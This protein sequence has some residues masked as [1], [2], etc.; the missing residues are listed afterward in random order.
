MPV[1]DDNEAPIAS[2]VVPEP[3]FRTP[4]VAATCVEVALVSEDG[5]VV[6][7]VLIRDSKNLG[8]PPIVMSY[9]LFLKLEASPGAGE[10]VEG[11]SVLAV[12]EAP[13]GWYSVGLLGTGHEL[14]FSPEE[15]SVFVDGCRDSFFDVDRYGIAA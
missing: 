6:D 11:E 1:N 10:F 9:A 13:D 8:S 12:R 14:T 2:K 4:S 7:E 15:W 3:C 5:L